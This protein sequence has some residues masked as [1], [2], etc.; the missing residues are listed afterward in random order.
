MVWLIHIQLRTQVNGGVKSFI[1]VGPVGLQTS[2]LHFQ[3]LEAAWG[4][5]KYKRILDILALKTTLSASR[6]LLTALIANQ[7]YRTTVFTSPG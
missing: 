5:A 3:K 1:F 4:Q 7:P 6:L 2:T